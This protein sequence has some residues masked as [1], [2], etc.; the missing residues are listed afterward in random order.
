MLTD[1]YAVCFD[2]YENYRYDAGENCMCRL[3]RCY[4]QTKPDE[5][6]YYYNFNV[7]EINSFIDNW[8]FMK[9]FFLTNLISINVQ[10]CIHRYYY[11]VRGC[12]LVC[13]CP[14]I[15]II[16]FPIVIFLL[17]IMIIIKLLF[18]TKNRH[19]YD[20]SDSNDPDNY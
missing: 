8:L 13:C 14:F 17:L 4:S 9:L 18:S 11:L 5:D 15:I 6:D 10:C 20:L 19:F 2:E 1:K 3:C 12:L 16:S 7:C